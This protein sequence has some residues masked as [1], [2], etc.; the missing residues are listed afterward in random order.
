MSKYTALARARADANQALERLDDAIQAVALRELAS[1]IKSSLDSGE[2][3]LSDPYA[4]VAYILKEAD[5]LD[6][7]E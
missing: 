1:E 4:I 3:A 5:E 2:G 7:G 6:G